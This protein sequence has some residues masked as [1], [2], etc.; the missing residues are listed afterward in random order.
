MSDTIPVF[1]YDL[2][3]KDDKQVLV[4]TNDKGQETFFS[5]KT[6]TTKKTS[7]TNQKAQALSRFTTDNL[8]IDNELE[9]IAFYEAKIAELSV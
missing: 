4:V 5:P 6:L 7:F 2:I 1:T 9:Q 8:R 3:S